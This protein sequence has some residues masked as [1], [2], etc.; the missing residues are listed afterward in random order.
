MP[1]GSNVNNFYYDIET[2]RINAE[3][4]RIDKYRAVAQSLARKYYIIWKKL[5]MA[6]LEESVHAQYILDYMKNIIESGIH[7][8]KIEYVLDSLSDR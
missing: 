1:T 8:F 2:M 6:N 5:S 3:K 7:S 4:D